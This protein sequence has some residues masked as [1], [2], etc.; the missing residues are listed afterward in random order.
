MLVA[1]RRVPRRKEEEVDQEDGWHAFDSSSGE[2]TLTD[3]LSSCC[4]AFSLQGV[5]QEAK[6]PPSTPI[7]ENNSRV[8]IRSQASMPKRRCVLFWKFFLCCVG[9]G[10]G[11]PCP[12][13][14]CLGRTVV[15]NLTPDVASITNTAYLLTRDIIISTSGTNSLCPKAGFA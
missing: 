2:R 9:G 11:T 8:P 7:F 14:G 6:G 1:T 4:F 12:P 13:A 3:W 15:Q 10:H 5:G